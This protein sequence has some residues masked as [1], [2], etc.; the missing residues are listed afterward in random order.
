MKRKEYK[1]SLRLI[2]EQLNSLD[3]YEMDVEDKYDRV[4]DAC[5]ALLAMCEVFIGLMPDKGGVDCVSTVTS[6]D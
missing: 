2:G 4:V 1:E 3:D 6:S 5:F